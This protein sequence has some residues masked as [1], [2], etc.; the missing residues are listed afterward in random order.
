MIPHQISIA[1]EV[2]SR[3]APRVLLADEVGLG[4]TIE[5]GLILH[6][7]HLTGRASRILVLLPPALLNQWFVEMFRRFQMSFSI[8]DEDRCLSLEASGVNP[9]LDSQLVICA[10]DFLSSNPN[11][12]EQARE[13]GWDLLVV[14][15]AHH[16]A[17]SP[18]GGGAE[19]N[20][21]E[22]LARSVPGL[23]LL[24]ATPQ[25]LGL[26]GHFARLRLLDPERYS[27]LESFLHESDRYESVAKAI[28]AL[29]AGKKNIQ[30][31]PTSR[32]RS[33]TLRRIP[34]W[35]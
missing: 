30:R 31:L 29:M 1:A 15:E 2:A 27:D 17:W 9:F 5:A 10:L 24:T 3:L 25:Q 12:A 20:L 8:F 4:K 16:L 18:A 6:R 21:V 32:S 33:E 34:R 13:A 19:Y 22:S 7:L 28:D 14:D 35:R 11:R 26:E 23:L